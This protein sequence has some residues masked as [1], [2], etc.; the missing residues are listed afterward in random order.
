MLIIAVNSTDS[1]VEQISISTE[2]ESKYGTGVVALVSCAALAAVVIVIVIF[3]F[4]CRHFKKSHMY[5]QAATQE[6]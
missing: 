1:S 5:N 2:P 6:S 3:V 4:G